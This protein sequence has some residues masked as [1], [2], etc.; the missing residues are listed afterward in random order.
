ECGAEVVVKKQFPGYKKIY[1]TDV[2]CDE[3]TSSRSRFDMIY[4]ATS[5]FLVVEVKGGDSPLKSRKCLSG[6][7][8]MVTAYQGTLLYFTCI[9]AD[10]GQAADESVRKHATLLDTALKAGRVRY[11]LFEVYWKDEPGARITTVPEYHLHE[12]VISKEKK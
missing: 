12:F 7:G 5:Y 1:N 8:R 2:S 3:S 11:L 6:S 9:L 4:Q 10:M